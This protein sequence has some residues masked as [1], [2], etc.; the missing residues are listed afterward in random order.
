MAAKNGLCIEDTVY[1]LGVSA[2]R[3]RYM[4]TL[5]VVF[6]CCAQEQLNKL[7]SKQVLSSMDL[8]ILCNAI[9]NQVNIMTRCLHNNFTPGIKNDDL[10]PKSRPLQLLWD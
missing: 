7:R 3:S 6:V 2:E 5:E 10:L 4:A 1:F 9:E 8:T